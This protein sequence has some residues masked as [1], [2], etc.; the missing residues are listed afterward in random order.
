MYYRVLIFSLTEGRL[1]CS[2]FWQLRRKLL[3]TSVYGFLYGCK[4]S[5]HLG[6]YQGADCWIVWEECVEFWNCLAVLKSGCTIL[7]SHQQWMKVPVAPHS[8]HHL[9]V[10]VFW[11]LAILRG[12]SQYLIIVLICIS[13]WSPVWSVFL[14]AYLLSVYLLVQ[15]FVTLWTTAHQAPLFMWF[16]RQEYWRWVAIPFSRGIFLT[17]RSNLGFLHCRQILYH[18]ASSLFGY[19]AYF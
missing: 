9:V 16:Y 7:H 8:Y 2:K 17:Q 10:S 14:D 13:W 5:T 19:L 6:K 11:I 15:L 1:N 18:W 12:V 4:F 3:W